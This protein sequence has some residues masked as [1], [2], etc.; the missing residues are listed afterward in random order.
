M[1]SSRSEVVVTI[2]RDDKR[3]NCLKKKA[4][5]ECWFTSYLLISSDSKQR[6]FYQTIQ[7]FL[8]SFRL[9]QLTTRENFLKIIKQRIGKV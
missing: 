3:K 9:L 5:C 1:H 7:N 6:P 8:K 4:E 2:F